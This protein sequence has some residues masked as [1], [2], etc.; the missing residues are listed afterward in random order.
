MLHVRRQQIVCCGQMAQHD[1]RQVELVQR[2]AVGNSLV[3]SKLRLL[4]IRLPAEMQAQ[5]PNYQ[6]KL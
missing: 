2:Q 6:H 4:F 1:M 3:Y 5:A